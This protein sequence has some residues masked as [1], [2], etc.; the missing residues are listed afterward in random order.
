MTLR[1][2]RTCPI[3][4]LFLIEKRIVILLFLHR[5]YTKDII[6]VSRTGRY[7]LLV[8]YD[9]ND[10]YFLSSIHEQQTQ[11]FILFRV[12]KNR[13][14][15]QRKFFRSI[16]TRENKN[17]S[18]GYKIF[19]FQ[20]ETISAICIV[21]LATVCNPSFVM[22]SILVARDCMFDIGLPR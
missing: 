7:V 22:R 9:N 4:F 8:K 21:L 15:T 6:D 13:R 11:R 12:N 14:Q 3:F 5:R 16:D 2:S 10:F 20:N 18:N 17:S 1:F 19:F